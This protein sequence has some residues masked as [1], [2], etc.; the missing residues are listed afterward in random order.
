M[1]KKIVLLLVC[2]TLFTAIGA[3]AA[4]S[5]VVATDCTFPPMEYLDNDKKPVGFD[6]SLM[7][8]IAK[9][10]GFQIEIKNIAWDGI[11]A[12]IAAGKYDIVAAAVSITPERSKAFDISEPYFDVYPT[13]LMPS[14]A[15]A[16]T[17]ADLKGKTVGGQIGN[18]SIMALQKIGCGAVIREYDDV[19]LAIEDM[20]R[21]RID[22]VACDSPVALYYLNKKQE[23]AKTLKIAM[24]FGEPEHY[25]LVVKKGNKQLLDRLNEGIRKVRENGAYDRIF[26]E[27]MGN[28]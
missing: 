1:I 4:D 28:S 25:G 21:G 12:G 11:F 23:Y 14:G 6:P 24:R 17:P 22:A 27:F 10:C 5:Y 8:E 3:Q 18:S 26:K 20:V 13:I 16:K 15:T 2:A 7:K 9:A 19:G